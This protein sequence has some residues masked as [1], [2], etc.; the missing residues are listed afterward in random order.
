[1]DPRPLTHA[2]A[3]GAVQ[4]QALCTLAAERA[5]AVHTAAVCAHPGEH[6]TLVDVCRGSRSHMFRAA[7]QQGRADD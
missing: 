2:G 5:L 6:L 7:H 3:S 4:R 1:M